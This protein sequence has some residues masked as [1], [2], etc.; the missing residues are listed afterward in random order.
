MRRRVPA[1]REHKPTGQTC[2]IIDG[3][4]NYLG[5]FGTPDS[6]EKYNR[7]VAERIAP[8]APSSSNTA[9]SADQNLT[10]VEL[11]DAYREWAETYYV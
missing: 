9:E 5:R 8:P 7:L 11:G 2:V 4:Q 3:K 6:W 10:V 1:Y